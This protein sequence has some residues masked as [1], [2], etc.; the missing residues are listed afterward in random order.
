[1]LLEE[2]PPPTAPE[3]EPLPEAVPLLPVDEPLPLDDE[4]APPDP[5]PLPP[6]MP[7]DEVPP[8]SSAGYSDATPVA[9]PQERAANTAPSVMAPPRTSRALLTARTTFPPQSTM[10]ART[11]FPERARGVALLLYHDPPFRRPSPQVAIAKCP[12]LVHTPLP[13]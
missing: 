1:L 5:E 10:R 8:P 9:H 3:S 13:E 6:P 2:P 4:P 7:L 12:E 11:L